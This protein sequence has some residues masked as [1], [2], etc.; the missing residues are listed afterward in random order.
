MTARAA[1]ATAAIMTG[2]VTA[3]VWAGGELPSV[4]PRSPLGMVSRRL[5]AALGQQRRAA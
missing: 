2:T 4:A 5:L 3:H 1:L